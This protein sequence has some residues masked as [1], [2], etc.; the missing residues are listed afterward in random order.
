MAITSE[1]VCAV[2]WSWCCFLLPTNQKLSTQL[3]RIIQLVTAKGFSFFLPSSPTG[4]VSQFLH[5]I[6]QERSQNHLHGSEWVQQFTFSNWHDCR[7]DVWTQT[8]FIISAIIGGCPRHC[9][10]TNISNQQCS[11][12]AKRGSGTLVCVSNSGTS[13]SSD[14]P[15]GLVTR[16]ATS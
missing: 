13:K 1:I 9:P 14:H 8:L 12:V 15:P 10:S 7:W 2:N 4:C 5:L 16:E 11:Q 3:G 6:H